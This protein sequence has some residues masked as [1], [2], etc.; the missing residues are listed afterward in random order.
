[1]ANSGASSGKERISI[2]R[3]GIGDGVQE[4]LLCRGLVKKMTSR[5]APTILQEK[6]FGEY[7]E[8]LFSTPPPL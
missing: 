8:G 4:K 2:K 7:V 1:M 6:P 5:P 3:K